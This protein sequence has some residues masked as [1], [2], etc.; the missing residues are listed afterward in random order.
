MFSVRAGRCGG[1]QR[2]RGGSIVV[3]SHLELPPGADRAGAQAFVD[4]MTRLGESVV[5]MK[6]ATDKLAAGDPT[7]VARMGGLV[8]KVGDAGTEM[9]RRVKAARR[10][11]R[12]YGLSVCD[13]VL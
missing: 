5:H 4:A 6:A 8:A 7:D 2:N 3:L 10:D 12:E 9:D 11:A 13:R 1:A